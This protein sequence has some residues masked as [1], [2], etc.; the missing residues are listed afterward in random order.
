MNRSVRVVALTGEGT[1]TELLNESEYTKNWSLDPTEVRALRTS[2]GV[3]VLV[4]DNA[5]A[6]FIQKDASTVSLV[7][8]QQ[9]NN[10]DLHVLGFAPLQPSPLAL[11][12][13]GDETKAA[14]ETLTAF[15]V[16]SMAKTT[17]VFAAPVSL[18]LVSSGSVAWLAAERLDLATDCQDS[19]QTQSCSGGAAAVPIYTCTWHL[20]VWKVSAASALQGSPLATVDVPASI[21]QRC[22][23]K[24]PAGLATFTSTLGMGAGFGAHHA[25]AI[26]P[27]NDALAIVV[28][29]ASMPGSPGVQLEMMDTSGKRSIT[30]IT[31]SLSAINASSWLA[32]RAGRIFVC[33]DSRC[34]VGDSSGGTSFS[35]DASLDL[36]SAQGIL[37]PSDGIGLLGGSA[38]SLQTLSCKH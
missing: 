15:D 13:Q 8:L 19:G 26:D 5:R 10:L 14:N 3:D 7:G 32:V 21:S 16:A 6:T 33:G 28:Q 17:R 4:T 30:G 31:A 22:D 27:T 11:Y 25:L 37:L 29:R 34:A 38:P 9:T 12:Y 24:T 36:L 23:D 2:S 20:D 1:A 18:T 35:F